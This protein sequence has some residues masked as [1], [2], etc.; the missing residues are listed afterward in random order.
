VPDDLIVVADPDLADA[1]EDTDA[2][3]N[4]IQDAI[5]GE[6]QISRERADELLREVRSCQASLQTLSSSVT[7]ENPSIQ[8]ILTQLGQLQEVAQRLARVEQSVSEIQTEILRP[9]EPSVATV[10]IEPSGEGQPESTKS[11]PLPDGGSGSGS[12]SSGNS[13]NANRGLNP[14][15]TPPQQPAKKKRYVKI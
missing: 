15:A 3:L 4:S 9:A 7:G 1:I 14:S 2:T 6:A 8:V 5:E 10:V 13:N 12:G 11:N